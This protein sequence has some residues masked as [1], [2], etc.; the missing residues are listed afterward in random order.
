LGL[1]KEVMSPRKKSLK[2]D[3]ENSILEL[4]EFL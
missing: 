4:D 1:I 2:L 3:F